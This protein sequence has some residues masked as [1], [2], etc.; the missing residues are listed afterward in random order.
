MKKPIKIISVLLLLCGC[1]TEQSVSINPKNKSNA[2]TESK[3]LLHVPS[4]EWQDQIIYFLM[5][6]RFADG[7]PN[8]N[9]LGAN[10]YN[11]SKESHYSGGDLQGVINQLDYIKNLG[12]TAVWTTPIVA[13]QWWTNEANYGGYHGYWAIDFSDVDKHLG[14]IDTYK[15]LS[16]QLHRRGM[17]LIQDIVVNH[18]GNF[19]NYHNGVDG[20]D[21]NDTAKNFFLMEKPTSLQPAPTQAPFD[22]I[23][24]NNTVHVNANI[25][26]WTP[27]I[28][29]YN[30]TSQQ[31]TY[32]LATLADINTKNPVVINRFKQIYGD[33]IKSVGV[34]AFRIDTVRYV[35]HEFF[36]KFMHDSDGI[37]AVAKSTGRDKF[38]AF[39]EVFDTSK[40]YQNDAE[41]RV[42]SYLG[43]EEKPELNSLISF[44]LHHELKTVFAQ[45]FPTEQLSYRIKQHME[46]YSN[47]YVI[48][49]FID[50]H[51]M[52]RF[53]ASGDVAGFKQALATIFTIPGIPV[54]YQ[55]SA[56]AM[57]ESRQAMFKGGYMADKDYFD[58]ETELYK[59]IAELSHLRTRDKL[60]TRGSL[61]MI[62]ANKNGPGLLAYKREY[63]GR[64]VLVMF[65]TSGHDILVNGM[66]VSNQ[67]ASLRTL[68][69]DVSGMSLDASGYLTTRFPSRS[70]VI[71]ELESN[72]V[73]V[74][75]VS[76]KIAINTSRPV[77]TVT[78]DIVITGRSSY[79]NS[80]LL[81]IKNTYLETAREITTD[82]TGNWQ[83]TYPVSNLGQEQVSLVVYHPESNTISNEF[84]FDTFV[85]TPDRSFTFSDPIG[86]DVGLNSNL[87][88]PTH[89]QSIGQQDII[90]A[91]TELGGEVLKLTLTMKQLT[92]DWLPTNGFDNVAFSLFFDLPGKEGI[93]TLPMLN[94]EM[95][96]DWTWDLGHVIYGWGNTTFSAQNANAHHQGKKFG[97]APRV[98]I[99]KSLKTISFSYRASD[100]GV[101]SWLNS[102]VY[103]TTWD[104][105]GEGAY[106]E[107]TPT[108][109]LWSFGGGKHNDAKIIDYLEITIKG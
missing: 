23:N 52:A 32:Q 37:H 94:A 36:H 22:L 86:D 41:Y 55:G 33:W 16:D 31:F 84:T 109:E 15:T 4:P 44:P 5:A 88:A 14:T 77:Q 105:T 50:N 66:K 2:S 51:D 71:A 28:K 26:N 70:I 19:F 20:Y 69:G 18:T 68:F 49:T 24:R 106:R 72:D 3:L 46:I 89:S 29:D 98:T 91:K 93:K 79:P 54:I 87:S 42:A 78:Q 74:A 47:P 11:P 34:D 6:D 97:I 62:A 35:E 92:N 99:D 100:F 39:G 96:F 85:E 64:T 9:D 90:E 108:P 57:I 40:A 1:S 7:N 63:Q 65:N 43:T 8:N 104:I 45:G 67:S 95:P 53:L 61:E 103:I 59:F 60:F 27:S 10:E 48:P 56:Q 73:N 30:D 101:T 80:K 58:Q 83:I 17:Y 12:A 25:Y 13:N 102:H 82:G 75:S 81:L 76:G 38:L 21:P 107:L